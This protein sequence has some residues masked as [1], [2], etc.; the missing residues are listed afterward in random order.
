M[1]TFFFMRCTHVISI[2]V[3]LAI[4]VASYHVG[5]KSSVAQLSD[6]S[7]VRLTNTQNKNTHTHTGLGT[8]SIIY[9][10]SW[11][12]WRAGGS[13]IGS[14]PTTNTGPIAPLSGPYT[15]Y[16]SG[17][18]CNDGRYYL[19]MAGTTL[20]GEYSY[21]FAGTDA[22]CDVRCTNDPL[23]NYYMV[24]SG[25]ACYTSRSC[26]KEDAVS[27]PLAVTYQK[28]SFL[29]LNSRYIGDD[30]N[31]GEAFFTSQPDL[32]TELNF[33]YHMY[34]A[35][36][37]SLHVQILSAAEHVTTGYVTAVT[38]G[39]TFVLDSNAPTADGAYVGK[40]I[41]IGTEH[42][43]ILEYSVGRRVG[44]LLMSVSN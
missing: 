38:D 14:T 42:R 1:H 15:Y 13:P 18:R 25:S 36:M 30:T 29:Y 10:A 34:G 11:T 8:I 22:A 35:G 9:S 17:K 27:D 40:Y 16:S 23:C 39:T 2:M 24:G 41:V 6:T 26:M 19:N 32:Y 4:S 28:D 33:W 7:L 12:Q 20:N 43:K 44:V 37:G 21:L 5:T 3:C 31:P